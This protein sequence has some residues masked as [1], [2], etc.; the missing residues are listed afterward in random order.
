MEVVLQND[1]ICSCHFVNHLKENGPTNFDWNKNKL[2][3]VPDPP[4]VRTP[5]RVSEDEPNRLVF[6]RTSVWCLIV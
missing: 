3:T 4:D 2:M 1:R 6:L 5:S